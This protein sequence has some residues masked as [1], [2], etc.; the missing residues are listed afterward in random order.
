MF[1]PTKLKT[2]LNLYAWTATRLAPNAIEPFPGSTASNGST[3]GGLVL[4]KLNTSVYSNRPLTL[5]MYARG[6]TT[7][8]RV[9]LDL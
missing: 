1:L 4:F 3:G 8:S 5:L 2:N 6:S 9:S 7:P